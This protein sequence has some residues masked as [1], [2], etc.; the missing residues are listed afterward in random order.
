MADP[1]QTNRPI[2]VTS[3]L[4]P[5]KLLLVG[6]T[7]QETVSR[8]FRYQFEVLAKIG[9]DV[10][11]DKLLGQ[12]V[13][14]ELQFLTQD[15]KKRYFNGICCRVSED[16]QDDR[17]TTYHL[18]IV[19]KFWLASRKAQSRIFQQKSV[20]D[21]LKKVLEGYD[22][23][24]ELQGTFEKRD[25]CVQYRETDFN[26]A[27][28]LMEEEGIYFF[29]KHS[30]GS[31]KLVVANTPQS[32]SDVPEGSK[33]IYETV[34][35][36][37]RPEDRIYDWHKVQELR[38]GKY[39]LR[40]HIFELPGKDL[41]AEETIQ[42]S[43]AVGKVTHKLKVGGNENLEL[44]DFPGEYAQRFDGINPGGGDQS[45]ERDKVFQDKDRT[46]K[47]RMQEEAA[48]S[49]VIHG[50]SNCRQLV[51]GHKFTL[52]RHV[53]ANGQYMLT[54]VSHSVQFDSYRSGAS[55]DF[56]YSNQFTCMP[57][58]LPYRPAR[59][60]PKPIIQGTQS[61]V[62][63]GPS[64]EEI[65]PDKYGRVK[66]QFHWDR[67]GGK[68]EKSSCWVRVATPWAGK[69]WGMIH[70]PRIGQEV[71]V[72]FE[73]G[74]PDQ[75]LVVGSVYNFEQM[76]PYTLPDNKTQSGLKSRS[77]KKAD[78]KNFNE[79]RFEDKKD[80]EQIYIHAEKDF[81]GVIENNET[82]KIGFEKKDK[83]NQSIEVFNNQELK[84]GCSKAS[85]G[86]QTI[87]VYKDRTETVET[88]NEMVTIKKGNRTVSVD[89]GNDTHQIK[90]GNRTVAVDTGNDTHQIKKGNRDVKIDMGNDAL[91]I[92]MGNQTT[93]LNLGKSSTQA[94]Q[95]I[96]LKVGGNSIKVDQTGI[97]IKGL[98]VKIEGQVQT[99]VKGLMT[100]ISG[101][102]MTMVKG[103]ITMI[104]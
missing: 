85:D 38:S 33:L 90:K 84:V 104:N 70:I 91:T 47:I 98:M 62:V 76:P 89:T 32:H 82:R 48:Q 87:T 73:E 31:H 95:G 78:S 34:T 3:P 97:T 5:D 23:T 36:G 20:P 80:S 75:P 72:A 25:Y 52:D 19:P 10:P 44:Y 58:A 92:K 22:A 26:F 83:G 60:T 9:T 39:Q 46:V 61:A 12:S 51:C 102:A 53:N 6:I 57:F 40:D 67:E 17:F 49:I 88:G 65:W 74:D 21:I 79:L 42:D 101:S 30:N 100:Q 28:R 103:A 59:I 64:G 43:V 71:V 99:E 41:K 68:N 63:V 16:A 81:D 4:G 13:T 27:C 69:N 24:F 2:S 55:D 77:S 18:E 94:M 14:A 96:E 93:K 7:G 15:S 8:L 37:H 35:G 50:S 11:F 86:S 66:V 1:K 45:A 54:S 56:H 29:F